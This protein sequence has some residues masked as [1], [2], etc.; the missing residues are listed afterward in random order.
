MDQIPEQKVTEF[1]AIC[2]CSSADVPP[3]Q[4]V[5]QLSES[6]G[7]ASECWHQAIRYRLLQYS[8]T[9][10]SWCWEVEIYSHVLRHWSILQENQWA[11][12]YQLQ[13]SLFTENCWAEM[14]CIWTLNIDMLFEKIVLAP[15]TYHKQRVLSLRRLVTTENRRI[16]RHNHWIASWV[17]KVDKR[18]SKTTDLFVLENTLKI[19]QI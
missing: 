15:H 5:P 13:V 3:V 19:Y 12:H 9:R 4:S 6:C 11:R 16:F 8:I 18:K 14:C 10:L 17:F 2:L 7:C 1:S